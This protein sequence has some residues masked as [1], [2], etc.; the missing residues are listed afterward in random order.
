M[1]ATPQPVVLTTSSIEGRDEEVVESNRSAEAYAVLTARTAA[2][3]L[4]G[5]AG[6]G[7]VPVAILRIEALDG[8][9]EELLEHENITA[10]NA[11]WLRSQPAL[12]VLD[13]EE[14]GPYIQ[15]L[16]ALV[17]DLAE[18]KAAGAQLYE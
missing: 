9:F 15:L 14:V 6:G 7:D 16:A 3:R 1:P 12:L 8:E 10:P 11:G 13:D 5:G 17:P 4:A 18:R 2:S